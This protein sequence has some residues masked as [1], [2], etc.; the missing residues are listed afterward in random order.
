MAEAVERQRW[1]MGEVDVSDDCLCQLHVI[2]VVKLCF[3]VTFSVVSVAG[4]C[5]GGVL[6]PYT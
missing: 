3:I 2:K 6:P 1:V 5:A 4:K